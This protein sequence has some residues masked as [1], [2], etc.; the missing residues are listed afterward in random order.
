MFRKTRAALLTCRR[1]A[2]AS[3]AR[4]AWARYS[5]KSVRP[6]V[7]PQRTGAQFDFWNWA[8]V[9]C[10][11]LS[12]QLV[13]GGKKPFQHRI[14]VVLTSH[15]CDAWEKTRPMIG[16]FHSLR[17]ARCLPRLRG[18]TQ[19]SIPEVERKQI[20]SFRWV[21]RTVAHAG[22]PD[23][24]DVTTEKVIQGEFLNEAQFASP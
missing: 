14:E 3:A 17:H 5:S 23:Y 24:Q 11:H 22:N 12:W 10:R 15:G 1:S 7:E 6:A 8:E 19:W 21:R 2:S 4:I 20:P 9:F 18:G 16:V 13:T